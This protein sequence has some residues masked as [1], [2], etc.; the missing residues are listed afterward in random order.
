MTQTTELEEKLREIDLSIDELASR[1]DFQALESLLAPDFRY[2]H[3]T[4]LSQDRTEWIDGLR[5]LVGKRERVPSSV[6]LEVHDDVAVAMGDLD[7]IWTEGRHAYDRYVRVYRLQE[8]R[9]L[10][11]SQRT[12]P[13]TD[14]AA[15]DG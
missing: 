12:V 7:I 4:G 9:W 5:P 8:G 1:G 15:S 14:R 3:S 13:A 2:N 11:I 6:Q 10:L